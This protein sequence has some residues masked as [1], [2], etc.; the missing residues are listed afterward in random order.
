MCGYGIL[1]SSVIIDTAFAF[2]NLK[3]GFIEIY[4]VSLFS[5]RS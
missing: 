3:H 2:L 5:S 1:I 4:S